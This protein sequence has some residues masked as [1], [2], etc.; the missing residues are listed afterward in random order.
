M[1]VVHVIVTCASAADVD[2][3]IETGRKVVPATRREKGC[4]SYTYLRDAHD[5]RVLWSVE[6]WQDEAALSAHNSQPHT[7][8]IFAAL[9]AAKVLSMTAKR[10]DV[11]RISDV[12][13]G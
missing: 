9:K 2:K 13:L 12:P 4:L 1:I 7:S 5:P 8:E 11:S 6:C 3:I 10:H